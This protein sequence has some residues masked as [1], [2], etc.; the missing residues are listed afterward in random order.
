MVDMRKRF[1]GN[2]PIGVSQDIESHVS[3]GQLYAGGGALWDVKHQQQELDKQLQQQ[4][5]QQSAEGDGN[6]NDRDGG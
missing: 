2:Q 5:Q 1:R 6:G 4:E 3:R